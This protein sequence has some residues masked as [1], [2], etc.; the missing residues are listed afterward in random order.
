MGVLANIILA[1]AQGTPVNH[2]FAFATQAFDKSLG[3]VVFEDRAIGI[4]SGYNKLTLAVQRPQGNGAT[5]NRNLK[6]SIKVETPKLETVSNSTISGIAPAP[7]VSYRPVA[8][9]LV[10]MPER[11]NLQ[12]R[13]DLQKFVSGALANAFVTDLFE[14]FE[15]PY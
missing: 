2:T 6:L 1:D 10:T 11:S 5:G 7:T 15:L 14:K 3:Q 4:Y 8:E 9:L 13:K 12:D